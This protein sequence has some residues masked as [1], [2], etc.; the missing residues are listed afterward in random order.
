VPLQGS[1][2]EAYLQRERAAKEREAAH[3]AAMARTQMMLEADEDDS[4]SEDSD[5]ESDE[6]LQEGTDEA[7]DMEAAASPA[8]L[9]PGGGG[10]RR[11]R[12]GK[13]GA[14]GVRERGDWAFD[15][16]EAL[17]RQ[18]L[19]YDIYL[20]G[21]VSR[22]T[23]FFKTAAGQTQ[24]FRMFPYVERKRRV[25]SYGETIDVGMWL[26]KGKALEEDAE[27]EEVREAKRSKLAE[28]EAKVIVVLT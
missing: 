16:E 17:T 21:N 4:E 5:S 8:V 10:G 24:R 1:E 12:G 18:L 11:R 20:K 26:R 14:A 25:D 15:Q 28:D 7:I 13:Q 19:S 2:L 23:S 3:Q 22:T 9:E 6:G 27:T